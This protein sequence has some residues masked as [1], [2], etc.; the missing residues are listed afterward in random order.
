VPVPAGA[1]GQEVCSQIYA[2]PGAVW[3]PTFEQLIRIDPAR[4]RRPK[5][6]PSTLHPQ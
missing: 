6:Y 1:C 3:V 2:T 4:M 5:S